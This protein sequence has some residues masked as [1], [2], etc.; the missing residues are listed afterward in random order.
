MEPTAKGVNR[1]AAE[2]SPLW[3]LVLILAEIAKRAVRQDVHAHEPP[4]PATCPVD[5]AA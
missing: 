3:P 1:P 5:T 4:D 2:A